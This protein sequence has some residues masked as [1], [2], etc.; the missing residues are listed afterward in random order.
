MQILLVCFARKSCLTQNFSSRF[1]GTFF[2]NGKHRHRLF[3]CIP[4]PSNFLTKIMSRVFFFG[5]HQSCQAAII[6]H[7][8]PK[9]MKKKWFVAKLFF[10]YKRTVHS[11]QYFSCKYFRRKEC[12]SSTRQFF[13]QTSFIFF[14]GSKSIS[15]IVVVSLFGKKYP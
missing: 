8:P 11:L 12:I 3:P 2:A 10:F 4:F 9:L 14:N 5:C 7:W 13:S 6:G 1:S 15:L